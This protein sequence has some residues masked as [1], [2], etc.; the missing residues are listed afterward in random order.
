MLK[1]LVRLWN[2]IEHWSMK[3]QLPFLEGL[4]LYDV[5]RFFFKGIAEGNITSRAGSISYSFFL[6]LF[7]GIIFL[8]TLIPFFPVQNLEQEVFD[9]F[10]RILPPD[11][12]E[13][14]RET[15][16]DV[17]KNKREGLLS[18]GFFLALIFTTNGVNAIVSNFNQTVHDI[19]E[20]PFWKQQLVSMGLTLI[21]SVFFLIGIVLIIFSADVLNGILAFFRLDQIS[22]AIIELVRLSLMLTLVFLGIALLY[23]YGASRRKNWRFFSPGAALATLLIILTSVGFSYYVANFSQYNKLYGSIGTL[24]V[25]LLWIYINAIVLIVG[26]ELNASISQVKKHKVKR[27]KELIELQKAT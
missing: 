20:R 6:A 22:P 25:I 9:V 5:A 12:W 13:A 18:L 21:L 15:I 10:E 8:F 3:V 24:I 17:M 1:Q 26:F 2:K 11:T 27:E 23:N 7:P 14:S 19:D 4:S 16:K